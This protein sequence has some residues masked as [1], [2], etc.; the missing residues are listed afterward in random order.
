HDVLG[1]AVQPVG[2]FATPGW[3]PR[4]EELVAPATQQERF[5]AHRLV[6]H[7]LGPLLAV[8]VAT[9]GDP[10]AVPESLLPGRVLDDTVER[11]VLGDDDLSHFGFSFRSRWRGTP[12]SVLRDTSRIRNPSLPCPADGFMALDVSLPSVGRCPASE[13]TREREL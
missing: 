9:R 2:E 7:D 5:G 4:G 11:D 13:T 10:A 8:F 6:E 3:P 12:R 1:Q